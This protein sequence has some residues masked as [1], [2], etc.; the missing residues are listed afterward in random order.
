MNLATDE[1]R[2]FQSCLLNQVGISTRVGDTVNVT[3]NAI[4]GKEGGIG[5]SLDASP[6][7]DRTDFPYTFEYSTV[8]VPSGTAVG[9]IQNFSLDI[10][11]NYNLLYGLG[12]KDSV[13]AWKGA[14]NYSGNIQIP[15]E[16]GDFLARVTG[17]SE[18]ATMKVKF[19]NGQTAANEKSITLTL[20]GVGFSEGSFGA[21][22]VDLVQDTYNF[23]ARSVTAVAINDDAA[24]TE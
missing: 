5:T 2:T 6:G 16:D 15:K 19:T 17:R 1:V 9:K 21:K 24:P 20:A 11:P 8:E 23:T 12:N 3:A 18:T 7:S 14:I 10:N 22:A 13:D 4:S